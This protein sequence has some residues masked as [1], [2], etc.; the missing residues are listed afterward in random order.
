VLGSLAVA[1]GADTRRLAEARGAGLRP[2][3]SPERVCASCLRRTCNARKLR[4]SLAIP[5]ILWATSKRTSATATNERR[6]NPG[7]DEKRVRSRLRVGH[8]TAAGPFSLVIRNRLMQADAL[9]WIWFSLL[10]R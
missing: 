10:R 3:F 9:R 2:A 4:I 7:S 8:G 5:F 6:T 1:I